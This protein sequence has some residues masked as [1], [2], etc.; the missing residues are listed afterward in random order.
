VVAVPENAFAELTPAQ[1][2]WVLRHE[3][4]HRRAGD[5]LTAWL[6]GWLRVLYWWNPFFHG[7]LQQWTQARE[8]ICD[9]AAVAAGADPCAY[10]ELLLAVAATPHPAPGT[11]HMAT[12]QPARR[13]KARLAALLAGHRVSPRTGWEFQ[14]AFAILATAL[15]LL[16]GGTGFAGPADGIRPQ[17]ETGST[18]ATAP[19]E[20]DRGLVTRT[21][22]VRPDFLRVI[23][24]FQGKSAQEILMGLGVA[25]PEGSSAVFVP[26]VSQ[27]IVHNT[28]AQFQAIEEALE[29]YFN[30]MPLQAYIS[31]KWVEID[32][33]VSDGP[34]E[35]LALLGAGSP[36]GED[37]NHQVTTLPEAKFQTVLRALSQR[38][39]VDLF[40]SPSVMTRLGQKATVEVIR[41]IKGPA[42]HVSTTDA[43]FLGVRNE[44]TV[45]LEKD[46]LR[47][48]L[49]CDL[50]CLSGIRIIDGLFIVKDGVV[51]AGATLVK[52][53][54]SA[55][56]SVP[57]GH[58][59]F[60][61]M[62]ETAP[63]RKVLFF[64][65]AAVISPA[66]TPATEADIHREF[67]R[68]PLPVAP[69]PQKQLPQQTGPPVEVV[70]HQVRL[71]ASASATTKALGDLLT[72]RAQVNN[73]TPPGVETTAPTGPSPTP[74]SGD[75][76]VLGVLSANQAAVV[77][78][79]V[80]QDARAEN[81]REH[82]DTSSAVLPHLTFPI[83][84]P[85]RQN[86]VVT[87][88]AHAQD[89]TIDLTIQK[90]RQ[91]KTA[92][93]ISTI[94]VW[95]G[96]TVVLGHPVQEGSPPLGEIFFITPTTTNKMKKTP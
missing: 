19:P 7:L 64:A 53:S 18:P 83:A 32:T 76:T 56:T 3:E 74:G 87:P 17:P 24:A 10:A 36:P 47:I 86:L 37:R 73:T 79:S 23:P 38:K 12:S 95:S 41:E 13:L 94:T 4:E 93:V 43:N 26:N 75:F 77:L 9:A 11:F 52:L 46:G 88:E 80:R 59:L 5:P 42:H 69:P 60:W 34:A 65:T 44:F 20:G 63:G 91:G 61:D 27:L 30:R 54:K 48:A 8:E 21:F 14:A 84:A 25:F 82:R 31:T 71:Q 45:T 15:L 57:Q 62:G 58:T 72:P 16:V 78:Q 81:F 96:Q 92:S 70:V 35:V 66:G 39:G 67:N 1:W 50:H 29:E 22:R 51:P 85:L 2:D 33:N 68:K 89:G 6:L 49:R 40:S 55:S 28:P 90:Q